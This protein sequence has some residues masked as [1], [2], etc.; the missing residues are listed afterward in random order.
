M[1]R[2]RRAFGVFGCALAALLASATL[3]A[4]AGASPAWH[5]DGEELKG[6]ESVVNNAPQSY[7]SVPGLTTWC[8]TFPLGMDIR[9][10]SKVG[11]GDVTELPL[12]PCF[13]SSPAC[14]VESFEATSLPWPAVLKTISTVHYL[15]IEGIQ[16]EILYAGPECVLNEVLVEVEGT[17]G[18]RYE[19][20]ESIFFNAATF[21]TTGS[22]LT[23][24]G[25]SVEWYGAL[26]LRATGARQGQALT[27]Q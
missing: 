8:E 10:V 21:K 27:V 15:I 19:S 23:A 24:L 4:S 20:D 9:N 12:G 25:G 14:T 26:T 7:F 3:T 1:K 18:A 5:F 13:T 2:H 22:K 16:L 11:E 6:E 17:A